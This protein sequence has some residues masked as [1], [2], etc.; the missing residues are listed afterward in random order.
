M[1]LR[2][3]PQNI[4]VTIQKA[5]EPITF[6]DPLSTYQSQILNVNNISQFY[7]LN[8]DYKK[9]VLSSGENFLFDSYNVK[10]NTSS[11]TQMSDIIFSTSFGKRTANFGLSSNLWYPNFASVGNN[12]TSTNIISD[13]RLV[14]KLKQ[15]QGVGNIKKEQQ[16]GF[17][18]KS[19][20]YNSQEF[21]TAHPL[22]ISFE[23]AELNEISDLWVKLNFNAS[24]YNFSQ[25]SWRP[26]LKIWDNQHSIWLPYAQDAMAY[27]D[28]EDKIVWDYDSSSLEY[29]QDK[30]DKHQ[31]YHDPV[32][33]LEYY[34]QYNLAVDVQQKLNDIAYTV[35]IT[36]L[37]TAIT[38][39][40]SYGIGKGI[41]IAIDSF[42][43]GEL[44]STFLS[45]ISTYLMSPTF[46]SNSYRLIEAC[47]VETAQEVFI[48]PWVESFAANFV[49]QLGGDQRAQ[50]LFAIFASSARESLSGAFTSIFSQNEG[51]IQSF[52]DYVMERHVSEGIS[53]AYEISRYAQE[54]RQQIQE[55]S[56]S[57]SNS[58]GK[59]YASVLGMLS[60]VA[61]TL[62]GAPL[63]G[64]SLGESISFL[65]QFSGERGESHKEDLKNII[66]LSKGQEANNPKLDEYASQLFRKFSKLY[67]REIVYDPEKVVIAE[68]LGQGR[69]SLKYNYNGLLYKVTE[70]GLMP[71][72][73]MNAAASSAV[74]IA[75]F[76]NLR[77]IITNIFI[78]RHIISKKDAKLTSI[79]LGFNERFLY[80][81]TDRLR[82]GNRLSDD[83]IYRLWNGIM[84]KYTYFNTQD[85]LRIKQ[86]FIQLC[87]LAWG[88]GSFN[89]LL[90]S[91]FE[92]LKAQDYSYI[93]PKIHPELYPR[94][95]LVNNLVKIFGLKDHNQLSRILFNDA[96]ALRVRY[97][98][99]FKIYE[100]MQITHL[101][102]LKLAI[103]KTSVSNLIRTEACDCIDQF[104]F[105]NPLLTDYI[106]EGNSRGTL[107]FKPE[108]DLIWTIWRYANEG[109]HPEIGRDMNK[110]GLEIDARNFANVLT[111][112]RIL[113][114]RSVQNI[115]NAALFSDLFSISDSYKVVDA[116]LEYIKA[117]RLK[118]ISDYDP[119]WSYE[120]TKGF[121]FLILLL[122]DLGI[123]LY[124]LE[125]IKDE[126]FVT[127]AGTD[128]YTAFRHHLFS[129]DKLS[130]DPN[131]LALTFELIHMAL[132][133]QWDL[134][135]NL[136]EQR[137]EN[138]F[139]CPDYYRML[140]NWE[141]LWDEYTSRYQ[142]L[143][144]FG[145][146][147]FLNKYYPKF[148]E[149]YFSNI[150]VGQLD[151][152]VAQLIQS[153]VDQGNPIP[154]I[155]P[156]LMERLFGVDTSLLLNGHFLGGIIDT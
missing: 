141:V 70:R 88:R 28:T 36:M 33:Y 44:S 32:Y 85:Y 15:N 103:L 147:N 5:D 153:W 79:A 63:L 97:L 108:Y 10:N 24:V 21:C 34:Y 52:T 156:V 3:K 142:Y 135:L 150:P 115:M 66:F 72:G 106:K 74:L 37:S 112:G 39:G 127:P 38:F 18:Y 58:F 154:I 9:N 149:R 27:S 118:G 86:S 148:L 53:S 140:P 56:L 55:Q 35:G 68:N 76:K 96:E 29:A 25:W 91:R 65:G 4:K 100:N 54:F 136:L 152:H 122:R 132:E 102:R 145:L 64:M 83:L 67:G 131:R 143:M 17:P 61:D 146:E 113:N 109:P 30:Y 119:S 23:I 133:G 48:D 144:E 42:A 99:K 134:L 14:P 128:W 77:N 81:V 45:R 49:Q 8:K 59:K 7:I 69:Y 31:A 41:N 107:Y 13:F 73:G 95:D 40:M 20:W 60:L 123:D 105:S 151:Q 124:N 104:I 111:M 82:K 93:S 6:E 62:V 139:E 129:G 130:I 101:W 110:I 94:L 125:K 75:E 138:P 114:F 11:I 84:E 98:D 116:C 117:R 46:G 155:N 87:D 2:A 121:H 137:L 57:D 90:Q 120:S 22:N 26:S 43:G 126:G 80:S 16:D 71:T 1:Q 50:Q 12:L 19:S 78:N 89:T 47:I 51:G 92:T